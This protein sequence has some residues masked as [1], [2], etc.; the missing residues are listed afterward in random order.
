[1]GNLMGIYMFLTASAETIRQRAD[2]AF[3]ISTAVGVLTLL[4]F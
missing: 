1:M 4:K 3:E 2:Y